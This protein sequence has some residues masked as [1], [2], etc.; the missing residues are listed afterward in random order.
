MEANGTFFGKLL[1]L[2][3]TELIIILIVAWVAYQFLFSK[4][5]RS[6]YDL[7]SKRQERLERIRKNQEELYNEREK[8]KDE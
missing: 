3:P 5:R 6:S 8:K 2:I 4:S 7:K 1:Q